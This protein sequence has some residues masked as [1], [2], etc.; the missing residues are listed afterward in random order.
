MS[1]SSEAYQEQQEQENLS[2]NDMF[3]CQRWEEEMHAIAVGIEAEGV[4]WKER[5]NNLTKEKQND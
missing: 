3:E 1:R 5:M 2:G 4:A